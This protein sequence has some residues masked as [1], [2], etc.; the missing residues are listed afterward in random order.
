[1]LYSVQSL[2]YVKLVNRTIYDGVLAYIAM[3]DHLSH[4]NKKR[5]QEADQNV[6]CDGDKLLKP[7]AWY[8][9]KVECVDRR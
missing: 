9:R 7:L 6:P 2:R 8:R 5:A 3:Y 1:M 4:G